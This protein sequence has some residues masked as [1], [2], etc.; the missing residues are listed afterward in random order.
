MKIFIALI[1]YPVYNKEKE[2]I[3]TQITNLDFH[4][5]SRAAKTYGIEKYFIASPFRSQRQ[6]AE[7]IMKHWT[8]GY[9]AEYNEF[10]KEAFLRT[11]VVSGLDDITTKIRD[12][13]KAC[14]CL[15][16][17]SSRDHEGQIGYAEMRRM[18][19]E[20]EKPYLLLFGTGWG[21]SDEL[22]AQSDYVLEPIKG[23]GDYNHLS[24]RSAVSI[25]LDRL[26]G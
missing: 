5:I 8:T 11:E 15:I 10:R 6:L 25:I 14:P 21:L 1:H 24:V 20:N 4:D 26:L 7:K 23:T 12:D 13:C 2:I 22:I 9:G 19:S 16:A 17:T 3:S 18:L